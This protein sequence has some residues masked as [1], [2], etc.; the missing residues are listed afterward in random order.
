M[1]EWLKRAV[2][3]RK[4]SGSNPGRGGHK[5]LCGRR[6]PSD[7]VSL[8][9][10]VKRQRFHTFNTHN[11]KSRTAHQYSLKTPYMLELDLG[12]FPPD[13]VTSLPPE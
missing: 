12:A 13:V 11:T 5:N 3:V 9:R 8:R 4:V 2:A 6:E 1:A 7:Y 10:A